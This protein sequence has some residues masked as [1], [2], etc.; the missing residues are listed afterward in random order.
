MY[1]SIRDDTNDTPRTSLRGVYFIDSSNNN[2]LNPT[3]LRR[4]PAATMSVLLRL[5]MDFAVFVSMSNA[6]AFYLDYVAPPTG[7]TPAPAPAPAVRRTRRDVEARDEAIAQAFAALPDGTNV[8][9][10]PR[11]Q[12]VIDTIDHQ[13]GLIAQRTAKRIAELTGSSSSSSPTPSTPPRSV[14]ETILA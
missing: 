14:P 4:T 11:D 7:P 5:G 2:R 13:R 12:I 1:I 6:T 10:T 3:G 9:L 8:L